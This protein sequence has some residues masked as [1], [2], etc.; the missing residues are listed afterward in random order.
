[1]TQETT[2]IRSN[3]IEQIKHAAEII[4]KSKDRRLVFE[5]VYSTKQKIKTVTEIC[6]K[7]GLERIRV[8]QEA[9]NLSNNSII[10][11]TK[12]RK[13]LA[14]EKDKFYTQHKNKILSLVGNKNKIAK[15]ATRS[16]PQT[17]IITI[18]V[19]IQKQKLKD[20]FITIDEIDS[21]VRVR[22]IKK[23]KKNH[24]IYEMAFKKGIQK[25]LNQSGTF[26]DWGGEKNDLFSSRLILNKK[27]QRVAFGFKG[28]GTSGVLTPKKM[29]KNGDQIQRLFESSADVFLVQYWDSISEKVMEQMQGWAQLKSFKENRTI[30]YGIIDGHD[31]Q[32]LIEAYKEKFPKVE[33]N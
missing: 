19:P 31:T 25:I 26:K 17:S 27:R 28:R 21:F 22:K 16:T 23:P 24:P 1:M 10:K 3:P 33:G 20:R 4:K 32:R 9:G 6:T 13:E 11:K 30:Y 14:Y 15:L 2:D 18:K 5:A 7:T 29:G 12:V 8:L